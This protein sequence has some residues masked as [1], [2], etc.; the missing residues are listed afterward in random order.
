MEI[1]G[2][3]RS[4]ADDNA[5][6]GSGAS[7]PRFAADV[8]QARGRLRRHRSARAIRRPQRGCGQGKQQGK[9][10]RQEQGGRQG[11]AAAAV[12]AAAVSAGAAERA[13]PQRRRPDRQGP[14]RRPLCRR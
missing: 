12:R 6:Q 8:L 11:R 1:L 7:G 9:Q 10:G 2:D 3:A 14:Q 5:C 13:Y 4:R